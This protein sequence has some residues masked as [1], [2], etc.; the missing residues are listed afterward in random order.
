M[1]YVG[2]F[3]ASIS[4]V[5]NSNTNFALISMAIALII[6][7][8]F[9]IIFDTFTKDYGNDGIPGDLHQDSYGNGQWEQGEEIV[10]DGF[11]ENNQI[12]MSETNLKTIIN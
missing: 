11:T 6:W 8:G 1:E 3:F 2:G 10:L 7:M 9:T 5:V 4:F 12:L